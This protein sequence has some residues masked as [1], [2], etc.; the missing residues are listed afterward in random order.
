MKRNIKFT[1]V[2]TRTLE[3]KPIETEPIVLSLPSSFKPVAIPKIVD[4]SASPFID[5]P[6][7]SPLRVRIATK[8]TADV[9]IPGNSPKRRA[10]MTI[11]M[12]VKSNLR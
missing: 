6:I 2:I 3:A 10:D 11:G 4:N 8:A 9:R 5:E 1:I 7:R 12:P